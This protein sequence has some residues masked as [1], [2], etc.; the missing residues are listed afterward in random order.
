MTVQPYRSHGASRAAQATRSNASEGPLTATGPRAE[1][2][3]PPSQ[4]QQPQ[5]SGRPRR[6]R[7]EGQHEE[8][9]CVDC[10]LRCG[11]DGE[12]A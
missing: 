11:W 5:C 3:L 9:D 7:N 4:P 1:R 6:Q 10:A 2:L 8:S 12:R